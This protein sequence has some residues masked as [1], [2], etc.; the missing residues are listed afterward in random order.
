MASEPSKTFSQPH[1]SAT[2]HFTRRKPLGHN[3]STSQSTSEFFKK[4]TLQPS[5]I[6][7]PL[8]PYEARLKP[9]LKHQ[10][11][12]T[13]KTT[14]VEE[15]SDPH[16]FTPRLCWAIPP[17]HC[18]ASRGNGGFWDSEKDLRE[19][20]SICCPASEVCAD[21]PSHQ[22]L[23]QEAQSNSCFPNPNSLRDLYVDMMLHC[24]CLAW[25][26]FH[27]RCLHIDPCSAPSRLPGEMPQEAWWARCFGGPG[28]QG[29]RGCERFLV[30][31]F[32]AAMWVVAS[33]F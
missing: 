31:R 1:S 13:P 27:P 12:E 30:F 33:R 29:I 10:R 17:N 24:Q 16:G 11:A 18:S 15:I 28:A 2:L 5:K 23:Q 20:I 21:I 3:S 32:F 6:Y 19:V 4:P 26:S 22:T 14:T 25:V 8:E 7:P 9:S